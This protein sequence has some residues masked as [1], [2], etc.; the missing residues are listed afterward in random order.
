MMQFDRGAERVGDREHETAAPARRRGP[1]EEL[2]PESRRLLEGLEV[3][4]LLAVEDKDSGAER[5][6]GNRLT[7]EPPAPATA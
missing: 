3:V 6:K 4:L 2:P 1:E 7:S 5:R